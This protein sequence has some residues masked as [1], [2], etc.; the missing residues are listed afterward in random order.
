MIKR[1]FYLKQIIERMWDDNIKVITG[2]RC[3]RKSTLLFDLF[4]K[5][6]IST[7]VQEITSWK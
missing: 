2:I 5:Y 6:L 7:G 3:G 1:N 4:K